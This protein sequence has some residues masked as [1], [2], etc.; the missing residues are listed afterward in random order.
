MKRFIQVLTFAA[1]LLMAVGTAQ[2]DADGNGCPPLQ[3]CEYLDESVYGPVE[4]ERCHDRFTEFNQQHLDQLWRDYDV[5]FV[6]KIQICFTVKCYPLNCYETK[7]AEFTC[8]I[9][10]GDSFTNCP[11]IEDCANFDPYEFVRSDDDKDDK[12]NYATDL[13]SADN[14]SSHLLISIVMMI[15]MPHGRLS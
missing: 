3:Q 6:L 7:M 8:E 13:S 2:D 12:S 1:L 4:Y 5:C 11:K 9:E 10:A 15:L 14:A